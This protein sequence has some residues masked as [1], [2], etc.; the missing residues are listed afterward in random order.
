MTFF[1][2]TTFILTA[3]VSNKEDTATEEEVVAD[4]QQETDD[5]EAEAEADAC[6]AED[7][8]EGVRFEGQV[9]Y[10]DGTL[11]DQSNTRI[12][13]CSGGCTMARWGGD[14]FCYPEGSLE[15]GV[16]SFKVVP[17]GFEGHATPLSV[18]SIRDENK[19]LSK[20]VSV[21]AFSHQTELIDG[22]FDAGNGLTINI[23]ADDY[24]PHLSTESFVAAVS[25]DPIESGLP[26]EGLEAENIVGMWYLG[27]FDA[28]VAP[29]WSFQVE[30][31]GLA[32]GTTVQILNASYDDHKWIDAGTATVDSEGLLRSDEDSGVANLTTILLVS[33]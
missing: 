30:D 29:K 26:L 14:G 24:T 6:V 27:S 32:V 21:P 33:E 1:S 8:A 25:V 15:P 18:V 28:A 17:F 31:T 2:M 12:H 9:R 13:M 4:E 19:I 3:C 20:D 16:Y 22:A 7:G 10:P 11:G 5:S 23:V